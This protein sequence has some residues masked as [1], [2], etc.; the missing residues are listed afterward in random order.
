[1]HGWYKFKVRHIVNGK[2]VVSEALNS[3]KVDMVVKRIVTYILFGLVFL[4]FAVT[5]AGFAVKVKG[6][7]RIAPG[8]MVCGQDVSGMTVEEVEAFLQ[9]SM[10]TFV[11]ELRCALLPEMQTEVE[12]AIRGQRQRDGKEGQNPEIV[13]EKSEAEMGEARVMLSGGE[14]CLRTN[15]PMVRIVVEDTLNA[16]AKKSSE[17]KVWEWL[18]AYVT[19][20]A[21]QTRQAEVMF[22]WEEA[23]FGEL[24][25][26]VTGLLERD[27]IE[28]TIRWEKGNITVTESKRGFRVDTMEAWEEA[29]RVLAAVTE[30][31]QVGSAKSMVLRFY[32][33][34][35]VLLPQLSTEQAK[36]C[37]TKLAEFSTGYSGAGTGRAKNIETGATRLHAKVIL[38]GEEFST[39]TA[40]MPFTKENG[41]M[42]GGTYIDGQ[43]SESIGGGVCQLSTTLY[44]ALLR[45]RLL[46]TERYS[47][48]MP[49]GYIPLGQDAAIAGD[50]K[51]LK[52]KNTT[53]APVLLLCEATGEKVKVALYGS[54]EAGRGDITMESII[55]EQTEDSVTV[56][57]Y[58][59]EQAERG[60]GVREKISTDKYRIADKQGS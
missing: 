34:G 1:M 24:L 4:F 59:T 13:G 35:E 57:V 56:E 42:T 11:T 53:T 27:C 52:F 19:G 51:D 7:G 6:A 20:S 21:F 23:Q 54:K 3:R 47:H 32:L 45:T 28:A 41:Y 55:T 14:L 44:N 39:A 50:Y 43:L 5:I 31:L 38:P 58:R 22:V 17:V 26:V 40:L 2:N 16:V 30:R 12:T 15:A 29:D 46:I 49:V 8:V 36:Q 48:S 25:S 60:A 37:N 10:P 9:R 33:D 18:Y